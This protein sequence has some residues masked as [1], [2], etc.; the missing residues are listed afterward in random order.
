MNSL[1]KAV[2]VSQAD[3]YTGQAID[4][5]AHIHPAGPSG[6]LSSGDV[7]PLW[8]CPLSLIESFG[9]RALRGNLKGYDIHN[10]RS[11]LSDGIFL[12]DRAGHALRHLMMLLNGSGAD[13]EVD[14]VQGNIDALTFFCGLINEAYRLDPEAVKLAF[15][16]E[17]RG[18][19]MYNG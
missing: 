11:G 10:W 6:A 1:T 2:L 16:A 17:P 7:P 12:R 15:Y 8:Q 3:L 9:R 18:E 13:D 5:P 19:K 14:P 4:K